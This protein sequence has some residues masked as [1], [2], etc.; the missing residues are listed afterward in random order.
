VSLRHKQ[1]SI[2]KRVRARWD[3]IDHRDTEIHRENSVSSVLLTSNYEWRREDFR[4]RAEAR[5][6]TKAPRFGPTRARGI[7][8]D[9]KCGREGAA[10]GAVWSRF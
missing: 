2:V 5:R 7:S 4:L 3:A 1:R 6:T 9:V 8:M 10:T